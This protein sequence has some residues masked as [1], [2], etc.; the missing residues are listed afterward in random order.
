MQTN[1]E[2]LIVELTFKFALDIIIVS[3][4]LEQHK[5]YNLSNQLLEQEHQLEQM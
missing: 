4:Q 2:N 1:K 3:E 5:R